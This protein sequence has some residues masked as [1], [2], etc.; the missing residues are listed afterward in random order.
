MLKLEPV[1]NKRTKAIIP[2]SF[3]GNQLIFP[4]SMPLLIAMLGGD[5]RRCSELWQRAARPAQRWLATGTT[6]FFPS[7]PFGV[8]AM[9]EHASPMTLNWRIAC[10]VSRH[11]QAKAIYTDIG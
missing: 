10:G 9:A 7:K 1:I 4:L 11:G 5:R 8:M 3:M 6:S 2:V